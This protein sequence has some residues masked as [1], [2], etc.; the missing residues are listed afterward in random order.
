MTE[1]FQLKDM[2]RRGTLFIEILYWLIHI[3]RM[4]LRSKKVLSIE[5]DIIR[6]PKGYVKG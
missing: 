1:W 5:S 2:P 4:L 6:L 3:N